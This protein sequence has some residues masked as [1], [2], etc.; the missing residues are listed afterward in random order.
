MRDGG[1]REA[2]NALTI[3][4]TVDASSRVALDT[5]YVEPKPRVR[6]GTDVP[7]QRTDFDLTE[8][9]ASRSDWHR[10]REGHL[11]RT[12]RQSPHAGRSAQRLR[13][14]R[15]VMITAMTRMM[16]SSGEKT[17]VGG[18]LPDR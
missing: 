14:S 6:A 1:G 10:I 13:S 2:T 15:A 5:E 11:T 4:M 7:Q 8:I 18:R 9:T 16:I 12:R 3:G 17:S